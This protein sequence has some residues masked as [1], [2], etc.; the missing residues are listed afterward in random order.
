MEETMPH[1]ISH[2]KYHIPL[3]ST[4]HSEHTFP[5]YYSLWKLFPTSYGI[6]GRQARVG[7]AWISNR[8]IVTHYRAELAVSLRRTSNQRNRPSA[9]LSSSTTTT[10]RL[11]RWIQPSLSNDNHP[12]Y[13]L[14]S[15]IRI[16]TTSW[17]KPFAMFYRPSW[18]SSPW[19]S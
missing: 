14:K 8:L 6:P 5:V 10:A 11:K 15:S 13:R 16:T 9:L 2:T 12:R 18:P 3:A 7:S 4:I 17:F 1:A 19:R